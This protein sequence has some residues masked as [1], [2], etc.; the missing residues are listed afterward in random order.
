MF[1]LKK[2]HQPG[3]YV[4]LR[5]L[6]LVIIAP[7]YSRVRYRNSSFHPSVSQFVRPSICQQFISQCFSL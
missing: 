2:G 5:A 6:F 7:A 3:V 4:P 1:I